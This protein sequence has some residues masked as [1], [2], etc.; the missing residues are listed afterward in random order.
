MPRLRRRCCGSIAV[1]QPAVPGRAQVVAHGR[2]AHASVAGARAQHG[3]RPGRAGPGVCRPRGREATALHPLAAAI[4]GAGLIA[5]V[6]RPRSRQAHHPAFRQSP[7]RDH[8]PGARDGCRCRPVRRPA[9]V[10]TARGIPRRC[11]S[12]PI[13]AVGRAPRTDPRAPLPRPF[14]AAAISAHAIAQP[15]IDR[16]TA[17][18]RLQR[19]P[20]RALA[21]TLRPAESRPVAR[22]P[23]HKPPARLRESRVH[24]Y[25]ASARV[26]PCTTKA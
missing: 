16:A 6:A 18:L 9:L 23:K 11:S 21:S 2:R 12:H 20:A 13:D 3:H 5:W 8:R 25:P 1:R 7:P 26:R 4:L 22:C 19:I 10:G 14:G 17:L 24:A 15:T